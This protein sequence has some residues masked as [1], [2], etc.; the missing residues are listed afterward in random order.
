[1]QEEVRVQEER[2][3][4]R[5]AHSQ[6]GSSLY[7]R[8]GTPFQRG[9]PS[10]RAGSSQGRGR[11]QPEAPPRSPERHDETHSRM[12][13]ASPLGGY[14]G[15]LVSLNEP[16]MLNSRPRKPRGRLGNT[17]L[18]GNGTTPTTHTSQQ[19]ENQGPAPRQRLIDPDRPRDSVTALRDPRTAMEPLRRSTTFIAPSELGLAKTSGPVSR[20]DNLLQKKPVE[21]MQ[22]TAISPETSP[23]HQGK[24]AGLLLTPDNPGFGDADVGVDNGR[25]ITSAVPFL[26][27]SED[28]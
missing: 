2:A 28:N 15:R 21:I 3:S 24:D 27:G 19:E 20:S 14:R 8:P 13:R 18:S 17:S 11:R 22:P 7:R 26:E 12:G 16:R 25:E 1:M 4:R 5:G 9:C 23:V 6:R 10:Q